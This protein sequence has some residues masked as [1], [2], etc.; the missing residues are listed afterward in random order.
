MNYAIEDKHW[1]DWLLMYQRCFGR[2]EFG[3][4]VNNELLLPNNDLFLPNNDLLSLYNKTAI[5]SRPL[6]IICDTDESEIN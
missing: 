1:Y 5:S 6:V 2:R 4:L 3:L